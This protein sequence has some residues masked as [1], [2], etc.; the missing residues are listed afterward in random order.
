[1]EIRIIIK[2]TTKG[3]DPYL[4]EWQRIVNGENGLTVIRPYGLIP[5]GQLFGRGVFAT[6]GLCAI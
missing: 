5:L 1:V 4:I 6:S 3:I 2:R